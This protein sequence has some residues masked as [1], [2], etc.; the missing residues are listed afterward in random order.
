[1]T[2]GPKPCPS[3]LPEADLLLGIRPGSGIP[4]FFQKNRIRTY[5]TFCKFKGLYKTL[6]IIE[7]I[8]GYGV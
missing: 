4:A 3:D 7:H 6:S 8:S 1:M 5:I 2:Q